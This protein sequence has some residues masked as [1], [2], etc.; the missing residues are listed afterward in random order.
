[1]AYSP[2]AMFLTNSLAHILAC[3]RTPDQNVSAP[4][5]S[6][7]DLEHPTFDSARLPVLS[8]YNLFPVCEATSIRLLEIT[9]SDD[10]SLICDKRERE[11]FPFMKLPC[12]LLP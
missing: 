6:P 7:P 11:S 8:K 2:G 5:A 1:M 9:S 3:K 10:A 12:S 4:P